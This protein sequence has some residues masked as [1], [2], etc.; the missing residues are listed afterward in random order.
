MSTS[1]FTTT[2]ISLPPVPSIAATNRFAPLTPQQQEIIQSQKTRALAWRAL[3]PSDI[4]DS[5]DAF[6]G[7]VAYCN[8]AVNYLHHL[9]DTLVADC[10]SDVLLPFRNLSEQEAYAKELEGNNLRY[11]ACRVKSRC[12]DAIR[13]TQTFKGKAENALSLSYE[14]E[15]E[16]G[17]ETFLDKVPAPPVVPTTDELS[18]SLLGVLLSNRERLIAEL[19]CKQAREVWRIAVAILGSDAC[20]QAF[21][22]GN[23]RDLDAAV[24]RQVAIT[25]DVAER[26]ARQRKQDAYAA[27]ERAASH[28]SYL[29]SQI[30]DVLRQEAGSDMVSFVA[31]VNRGRRK[32]T[33]NRVV[34]KPANAMKSKTRGLGK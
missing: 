10:I 6:R 32:V 7:L 28:G 5:D 9:P 3:F 29:W 34:S 12:L 26:T 16:A 23:E 22:H 27:I 15:S 13:H 18:Q 20:L 33:T 30:R 31:H 14:Y 11:I 1:P 8:R 4:A 19:K 24:T 2:R 17:T 21:S 25:L